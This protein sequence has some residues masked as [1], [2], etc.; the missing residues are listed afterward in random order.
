MSHVF[1]L[2]YGGSKGPGKTTFMLL[3]ASYYAWHPQWRA[4]LLRKTY[5]DLK[6]P[7]ALLDVALDWWENME[8]VRYDKQD[9]K[10]TFDSGATIEFGHL[11][12]STAHNDYQGGEQ[13]FVGIDESTQVP[14]RQIDLL[15]LNL[16]P[17]NRLEVPLQFRLCCNPGT[18]SH[19]Y[20][21][22]RYVDTPNTDRKFFL[23]ATAR[24][25]EHVDFEEYWKQFSDL[26]RWSRSS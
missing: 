8:G 21:K 17:T 12:S 5:K 10:F 22:Q 23:A 26:S 25:N 7:G 6:R 15:R 1:D 9:M 3:A 13:T 18:I 20:H 2:M 24:D 11:S 16:R 4:L 14:R 19:N